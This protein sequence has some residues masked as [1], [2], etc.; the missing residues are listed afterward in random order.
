MP[1]GFPRIAKYSGDM[2]HHISVGF[3]RHP[4]SKGVTRD[5]FKFS[6]TQ[7]TFQRGFHTRIISRLCIF[8]L[9]VL[10]QKNQQDNQ[11]LYSLLWIYTPDVLYTT[12]TSDSVQRKTS[13]TAY[14]LAV[15]LLQKSANGDKRI[16][17]PKLFLSFSLYS[18]ITSSDT[19]QVQTRRPQESKQSHKLR[20]ESISQA[21]SE[22]H[23]VVDYCPYLKSRFLVDLIQ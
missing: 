19:D 3:C 10:P 2:A 7:E 21:L 22:I 9:M 6:M 11:Q 20:Q 12:C 5:L 4:S 8:L 1:L 15:K 16:S 13:S 14:L 17:W 23:W 18:C